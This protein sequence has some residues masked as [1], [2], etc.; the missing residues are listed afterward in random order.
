MKESIISQVNVT[1]REDGNIAILY[2]N[3]PVRDLEIL[4]EKEYSDYPYL[5]SLRNYMKD[6]DV[7]THDYLD[8]IDKLRV[9]D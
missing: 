7:V 3:V 5:S 9:S 1:L 6:L 8:A 2:N 4:F